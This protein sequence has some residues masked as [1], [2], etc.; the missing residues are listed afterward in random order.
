MGSADGAD[1]DSGDS[2]S[3]CATIS[4]GDYNQ[5]CSMDSDCVA[6]PSG[7]I[8]AGKC[9]CDFGAINVTDRSKYEAAFPNV[10]TEACPCQPL[11]PVCQNGQCMAG[12]SSVTDAGPDG[13]SPESGSPGCGGMTCA[14]GQVCVVDQV[15][16][17]ALIAPDDAG[18]CPSGRVLAGSVCESPPSYQCAATPASCASGL[19]CSCATSLCSNPYQCTQASAATVHCD[20]DAP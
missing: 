7:S 11:E 3:S 17:G 10:E 19:S 16:G 2:G 14:N 8:C 1:G 9:A 5:K 12:S 20:L 18:M 6:V 13:A 15:H 4:A